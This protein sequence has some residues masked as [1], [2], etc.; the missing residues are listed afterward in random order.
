MIQFYTRDKEFESRLDSFDV[1]QNVQHL[2]YVRCD[3]IFR[4]FLPEREEVV[5]ALQRVLWKIL[6][7]Q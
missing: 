5:E 2:L 6:H 4:P 3:V 7:P 1:F